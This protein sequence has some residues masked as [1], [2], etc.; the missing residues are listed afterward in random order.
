MDRDARL[1][2]LI[3]LIGPVGVCTSHWSYVLLRLWV[4]LLTLTS[5]Y[6]LLRLL[7]GL[8]SRSGNELFII[9]FSRVRRRLI[10]HVSGHS[11]RWHGFRSCFCLSWVCRWL[12]HCLRSLFWP[13]N[14]FWLLL[15]LCS[16]LLGLLWLRLLYNLLWL[17]LR[18]HGLL[19]FLYLFFS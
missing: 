16:C 4:R 9:L 12:G 17:R 3:E 18:F 6:I 10:K 11:S 7:L 8:L 19:L 15:S 14:F 1:I 2:I 5:L 13:I